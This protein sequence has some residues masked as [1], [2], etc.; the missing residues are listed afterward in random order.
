MTDVFYYSNKSKPCAILLQDLETIPHIRSKFQ[1]VSIDSQRPQHPIQSVPAAV[2]EGNIYQGKQVFDWLAKE[3]HNNTL[4]AFEVGFGNNNFTSIHDDKAPAE[5]NHNFT[6]IEDPGAGPPQ[7]QPG[8]G[9]SAPPRHSTFG[10]GE[11]GNPQKDAK[12]GGKPQKIQDNALD[13][14]INQRKL[15]IPVPR[16]RA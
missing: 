5:N 1:F 11:G 10:A 2:I 3:K 7:G 13:D 12:S 14:L 4:P 6:Y 9:G 16:T 15:D 8:Q